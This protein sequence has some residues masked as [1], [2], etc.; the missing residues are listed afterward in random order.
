MIPALGIAFLSGFIALSYEILWY[1]AFS[2]ASGGR[3][4]TFGLML[5]GYLAGLAL[6]SLAVRRYCRDR[7]QTMRGL[8]LLTSLSNLLGFLVVPALAG[9]AAR[10][11]AW[12]H[13][14]WGVGFAAAGLGAVFP[15]VSHAWIEPDDKVGSKLSQVYL[16]NILGSTLG[17]LL[18]GFVL[19]DILTL[20]A[21]HQLLFFLGLGLT[22]VVVALGESRRL[23][24]GG[25][26]VLAALGA[27]FGRVPFLDLYERLQEKGS[28]SSGRPFAHVVETK[29]GVITVND[30]GQIFGGG[31]YDGA[32]NTSLTDDRNLILRCYALAELHPAPKDVLLIGLSSGSWATVIA[33]NPSVERLTIVEI[34]P[35]YLQLLPKYSDVAGLAANAKV[36][37]EIDDGRRWLVRN[38]DRRFDLIVANATFHWRSN[39]TNL[40]SQEFLELVRSRLKPGGMYYYNTTS[41]ARVLRTGCTVFPHALRVAGFLAVS[42]VPLGLD[43]D[44][45]RERLFA[46]PRGSGVVIDRDKPDEVAVLDAAIG[47]LKGMLQTRES[48]LS[49]LPPGA[50]VTDDNMGTEWEER[51]DLIP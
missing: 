9:L 13:G 45:L 36:A 31:I 48:L 6:G 19:A 27:A 16:A 23:P 2:F 25:L 39:A 49:S 30:R 3:A 40:L 47:K 44:R 4:S 18:T 20:A 17:S 10:G 35:G 7:R 42:D 29:S 15:M 5:G 22:A 14:L 37:I 51:P 26:L 46:Y 43:A 12:Q 50:L 24:F 32:F 34:N 1:R 11:V 33:G 8:A 41:S 38:R 28:Y 21:M